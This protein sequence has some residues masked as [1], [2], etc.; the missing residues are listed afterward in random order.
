M[1]LFGL[2]LIGLMRLNQHIKPSNMILVVFGRQFCSGLLQDS[3]NLVIN[4][5]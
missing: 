5:S 3:C 2:N 1:V 4:L